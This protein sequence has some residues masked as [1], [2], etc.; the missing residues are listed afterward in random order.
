VGRPTVVFKT[1][2]FGRSGIPPREEAT[3]GRRHYRAGMAGLFR[4]TETV[5]A[6]DGRAWEVNRKLLPRAVPRFKREKADPLGDRSSSSGGSWTD[7]M[8]G[9]ELVEA[10]SAI[11][12]AIVMVIAWILLWVLIVPLAI[13]LF[14][15]LLFLAILIGGIAFKV[16]F[17]RPWKVE[18]HSIDP[19]YELHA[20]G[21]VGLR[22]SRDAVGT[23]AR[24]L[25]SGQALHEIR[26][27]TGL[28]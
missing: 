13:F 27:A 20:W 18:A 25:Q 26:P 22:A 10:P 17:R 23:V 5:V 12:V 19:P 14:D 9:V 2:P 16:L 6:P 3:G 15:V 24:A 11:V 21:V 7:G 1:T 4:A 8:G 28:R